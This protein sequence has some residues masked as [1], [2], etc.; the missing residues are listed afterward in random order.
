MNPRRASTT[1]VR[2]ALAGVSFV[3]SLMA[4]RAAFRR[5]IAALAAWV[6]GGVLFV[7]G[8][9]LVVSATWRVIRARI[10]YR[11]RPRP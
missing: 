3:L 8:I 2:L 1:L 10:R 4:L 9:L 6:L 11:R 5:L 7:T